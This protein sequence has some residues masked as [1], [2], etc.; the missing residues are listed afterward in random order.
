MSKKDI[1]E[2]FNKFAGKEVRDPKALTTALDPVV[3]EMEKLAKDNNLTLYL[4]WPGIYRTDIL[5]P[6]EITVSVESKNGKYV[7]TIEQVR[8]GQMSMKDALAQSAEK[9]AE[10]LKWTIDLA[11]A[12]PFDVES[13]AIP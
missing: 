8:V 11:I 9:A 4:A 2:I 1:T 6:N 12:S 13:I 5:R 10:L 3:D 7:E